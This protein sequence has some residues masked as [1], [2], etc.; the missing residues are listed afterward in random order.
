MRLQVPLLVG[1]VVDPMIPPKEPQESTT[2]T[3]AE[4]IHH[5]RVQVLDRA[6]QT[7][8]TEAVHSFGVSRTTYNRWAGRAQRY[9]LAALVPKGRRPP[10]MPTA[11][12]PDQVEVVL[13]EA[14]ARPTLG[15]RQ[16]VCHLADRGV[17]LSPSG[18]QKILGRHR[19]GRRGQ[20]VAALA[21]LTAATTGILTTAAKDGPFGF[22]HFAARPGDLVALDTFYVGKLKDIGPVWQ[23][24]AV[25][26]ATRYAIG[27]LV[28]GD[29]SAREAASFV[30][31]VAERLVG[32]GV[33]LTGVLTDNGPKFTGHQFT[34]AMGGRGLR[35]H[36]IPPRSP[37]H[38]AVCER[39]QGTALQEFYRPAF[40]RQR[41]A[42]LADLNAQ[43]QS[44]A[45][46][47]QHPAPQPRRLHARPHALCGHGGAPIM[48]KPR[49]HPSP[50]PVLR[51]I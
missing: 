21:Q 38:N 26:T 23:L 4:I 30:D 34:A 10:V 13:A 28:A 24:T 16:L 29:K 17:R 49:V 8:V 2:M 51:K 25:D 46:D 6:G 5:R 22:C 7:S 40:H 44:W 41:F 50:Q 14:I 32:I 19:L 18:V 35:H 36:R 12:P 1:L 27:A 37:N 33:E 11:T 42:R 47:L 15:A 31:H 39:F 9:R 3:P 48:T 45:A 20:R 43:F